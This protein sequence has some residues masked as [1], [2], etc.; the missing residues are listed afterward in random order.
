M[1]GAVLLYRGLSNVGRLITF[2]GTGVSGRHRSQDTRVAEAA[3]AAIG[4][5]P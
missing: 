2:G 3:I 1:D 5:T 4:A